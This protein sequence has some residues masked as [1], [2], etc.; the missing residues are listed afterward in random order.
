MQLFSVML[1]THGDNCPIDSIKSSDSSILIKAGVQ[2][3]HFPPFF[4]LI[5]LCFTPTHTHAHTPERRGK[6][7]GVGR[8]VGGLMDCILSLPGSIC[9]ADETPCLG[10]HHSFFF[11]NPHSAAGISNKETRLSL[12]LWD[13]KLVHSYLLPHCHVFKVLSFLRQCSESGCWCS[14]NQT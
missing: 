5:F 1:C 2:S 13:W 6:R 7:A 10:R 14:N 4:Q 8:K 9:V 11:A 3:F 12:A